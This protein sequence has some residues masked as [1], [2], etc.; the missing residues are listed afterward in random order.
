MS[1]NVQEKKSSKAII[2]LLIII[3]LLLIGGGVFAVFF[4][5]KDDGGSAEADDTSSNGLIHYD[6]AAAPIDERAYAER[7]AELYKEAEEGQITLQ[8][9]T[10]AYSDDGKHFYCEIGNS[11]AN[12]Y[13]MYF[14]IY[15]D[16]SFEEQILLTG[17]FPPGSGITEFDSEIQFE[18]GDYKVVLALTQVEDDHSTVHAQSF[19]ALNLTVAEQ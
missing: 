10:T 8:Y 3:I 15:T 17:L 12:H 13:D 19:V 1:E 5:N 9:Q 7:I 14:N 4:F 11:A 16:S 18:P 2:I 6:A